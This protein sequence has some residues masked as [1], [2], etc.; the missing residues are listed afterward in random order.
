MKKLHFIKAPCHQ[1]SRE[2]GYQFG[3][4]EIKEKYDYEIKTD[5]FNGSSINVLEKK[6]DICLG[7][8]LL[9]KYIIDYSKKNPNEKIITIG[10]DHS[11]SAATIAAMNEKYIKQNGNIIKSNLMVIWIDAYPDIDDFDTSISKDLNEMPVASLL[12][13]CGTLFTKNKLLLN[14]EQLIY[15]GLLDEND[16][17]DII[18]ENQISYFT[19]NKIN[20]VGVDKIMES[21]KEIIGNRPVHI[22]LDLKVFNKKIAPSVKPVNEKG[23]HIEQVEKLLI[24]LKNNIVSMDLVE[25]NPLVGSKNDVKI[26]RETARY[27]LMKTFDI[28]EKSINI[29]TEDSQF[30]IFRSIEQ[31]DPETDI[32]WYILRGLSLTEKEKFLALIPN[33]TIISIDIENDFSSEIIEGTYLITKT[34]MNEQNEKSYYTANYINDT[35]LFPE[36]KILMCFELLNS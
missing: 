15:Y 33:D 2:Q 24:L 32:G 22:S 28:K 23:L 4:D 20:S 19:K 17:L 30:L 29:F 36:E 10:G 8:D 27:I 12:G 5:F 26:T 13:M 35:T 25:F 1:S 34:N 3:P 9:Y 31:E 6:I 7:Y 16:N 14:P 18:K 21:I 11:I